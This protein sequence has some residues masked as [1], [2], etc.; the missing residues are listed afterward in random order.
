MSLSQA[1]LHSEKKR[2]PTAKS[3]NEGLHPF[4]FRKTKDKRGTRMGQGRRQRGCTFRTVQN[5]PIRPSCLPSTLTC[6]GF[7]RQQKLSRGCRKRQAL[8]RQEVHQA[9]GAEHAKLK[10]RAGPPGHSDIEHPYHGIVEQFRRRRCIVRV[11]RLSCHA[12]GHDLTITNQPGAAG[13]YGRK[14]LDK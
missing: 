7:L 5:I 12:Y 3:V 8:V 6:E 9:R 4:V 10:R 1:S 13:V 2:T 11:E 14:T